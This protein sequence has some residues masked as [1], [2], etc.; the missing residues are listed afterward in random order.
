MQI[1][2]RKHVIDDP[3]VGYDIAK[4]DIDNSAVHKIM[5]NLGLKLHYYRA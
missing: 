4:G 2:K 5:V 3:N 1:V